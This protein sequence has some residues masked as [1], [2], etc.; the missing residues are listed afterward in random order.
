MVSL[1]LHGQRLTWETIIW[2]SF[3]NTTERKKL[4]PTEFQ[5]T[6]LCAVE[7]VAKF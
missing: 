7:I 1:F 2:D 6:S 3:V 5:M 4:D